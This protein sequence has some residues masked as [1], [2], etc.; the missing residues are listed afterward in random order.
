MWR[1]VLRAMYGLRPERSTGEVPCC[2][3]EWQR[4]Q[5]ARAGCREDFSPGSSGHS[6]VNDEIWNRKHSLPMDP[7]FKGDHT[8][9][10]GMLGHWLVD[11]IFT[12]LW[13]FCWWYRERTQ[14]TST[15]RATPIMDLKGA[16]FLGFNPETSSCSL[17]NDSLNS[18]SDILWCVKM[19]HFHLQHLPTSE[20]GA[21]KGNEGFIK[22]GTPKPMAPWRVS[23]ERTD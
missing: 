9:T 13:T 10:P 15:Q 7:N 21:E 14:Q 6:L 18:C 17:H 8:K 2:T 4:E 22:F 20:V 23:D 5:D 3:E 19:K 1:H 12:S 11:M 16:H